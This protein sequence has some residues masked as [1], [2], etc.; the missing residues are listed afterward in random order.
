MHLSVCAY[1]EANPTDKLVVDS[2]GNDAK[3]GERR[4]TA[5]ITNYHNPD[6]IGCKA[7]PTGHDD[8][9]LVY[10]IG[11]GSDPCEALEALA[12]VIGKHYKFV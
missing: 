7:F 6:I 4:W 11:R 2:F 9:P 1:L 8:P 3:T 5:Y 10:A 12:L